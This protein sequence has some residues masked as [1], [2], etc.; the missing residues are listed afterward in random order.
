MGNEIQAHTKSAIIYALAYC[1]ER[2]SYYGM[3]SLLVLLMIGSVFNFSNSKALAIYGWFTIAIYLAK[4]LG[5]ILGDLLIGNR[6]TIFIGGVLQALGCFILSTQAIWGLYLGIGLIVLGTGLF[7]SNTLAQFGKQYINKPRQLDSG[8]SWL[9]AAVN[10]GSFV[11]VILIGYFGE[12]SF[13]YGFLVAGILMIIATVFVV[14]TNENQ[15]SVSYNFRKINYGKT[16]F[17]ISAVILIS[18]VFWAIYEIS[19]FGIFTIQKTVLSSADLIIPQSILTSGL[20]SYFGIFIIIALAI[21]WTYVYTNSF[22][23][24]FIGLILS[25]LSFA[26]LLFFPEN[27]DSSYMF[28]FLTAVFLLSA[29][30]MFIS[31]ILFSITTRFSNPKYLAIMLCVVAIPSMFFFKIAGVLSEHSSELSFNII[32]IASAIILLSLSIIALVLWKV[33]KPENITYLSKEAEEFLS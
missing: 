2:A 15:E 13:S 16:F 25:A 4:G 3:R 8:F 33:F 19:Y 6:K 28:G 7:S 30:E 11:G 17:Y 14:F 23:K 20:N 10:F 5:A 27:P 12:F 26:I 29:G 24:L 1:L 32:F 31:P 9:F 21:I 18:G 22:L